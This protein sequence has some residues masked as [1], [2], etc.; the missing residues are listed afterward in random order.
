MSSSC[1]STDGGGSAKQIA[2]DGPGTAGER[3]AIGDAG[4]SGQPVQTGQDSL[5]HAV[6]SWS[7]CASTQLSGILPQLAFFG[8]YP[9]EH[10]R[11]TAVLAHFAGLLGEAVVIPILV[12]DRGVGW[13]VLADRLAGPGQQ[14]G[15]GQQDPRRPRACTHRASLQ[16]PTRA[17]RSKSASGPVP[18]QS[19]PPRSVWRRW[20]WLADLGASM[21]RRIW[22]AVF[23]CARLLPVS[24]LKGFQP[25][26]QVVQLVREKVQQ[27]RLGIRDRQ[28]AVRQSPLSNALA[29]NPRRWSA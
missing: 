14:H 11:R 7:A 3:A 17:S 6:S 22:L 20:L 9:I 23:S 29:Y 25:L 10:M 13:V 27:L 8:E 5:D 2:D 18:Q 4:A 12:G 28:R 15:Q 19:L 24:L 21:A 16:G 1:K 26:R